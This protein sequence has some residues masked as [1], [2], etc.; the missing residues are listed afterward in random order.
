MLGGI[1]RG[2][3]R[4]QLRK[5]T[6]ERCLDAVQSHLEFYPIDIRPLLLGATA[7][8]EL[9]ETK[10]GLEWTRRALELDSQD[11]NVLYNA[12]C[13]F[14]MA[15]QLGEAMSC[16]E[17]SLP[18]CADRKWLD[19]DSYLDPLRSLH[20]FQELLRLP[21]ITARSVDAAITL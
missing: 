11:P 19:Y 4:E 6:F 2:Q 12:A 8:I 20:R 13:A 9:G 10:R 3:K 18:F 14:C 21:R 15:G 7:L 5:E 17:K 16:L 1:Y